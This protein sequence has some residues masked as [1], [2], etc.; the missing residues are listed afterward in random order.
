MLYLILGPEVFPRVSTQNSRQMPSSWDIEASQL[1]MQLIDR[2]ATSFFQNLRCC[3]SQL[4]RPLEVVTL[5][6]S[7]YEPLIRP[8]SM[9]DGCPLTP[10]RVDNHNRRMVQ[11]NLRHESIQVNP[12]RLELNHQN[13]CMSSFPNNR[14]QQ[15]TLFGQPSLDDP[16]LDRTLGRNI[17][18]RIRVLPRFRFPRMSESEEKKEKREKKISLIAALTVFILGLVAILGLW[19]SRKREDKKS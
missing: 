18:E 7:H 17:Y 10:I 5:Y 2:Q 3:P 13:I 6:F 4:L 12:M 1:L 8:A 11:K 16:S 15:P 9:G 14:F 19:S